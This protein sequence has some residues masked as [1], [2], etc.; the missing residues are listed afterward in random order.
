M[1][2]QIEAALDLPN[3][4]MDREPQRRAA[5]NAPY[6]GRVGPPPKVHAH[7]VD[8]LLAAGH[9]QRETTE[10]LGV[11]EST[12][13]RAVKKKRESLSGQK[14][15]SGLTAVIKRYAFNTRIGTF[16]IGEYDGR[17]H[18]IFDDESLGS[19]ATAQQAAEDL[20]G[21]HTFSVRGGV[22]TASLGIPEDVSEWER[23]L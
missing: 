12:I 2:R 14:R 16:Y 20:A 15:A 13:S 9:T 22:D 18:P 8:E 7:E 10:Q 11:H 19:Y 21:G 6:K 5:P 17:F 23:L 4:W 1:A 3:G